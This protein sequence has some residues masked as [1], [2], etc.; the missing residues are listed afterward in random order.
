M[1]M[2]S[3]QQN[4]FTLVEVL[5]ALIV[6]AI[7][8][9]GLITLQLNTIQANKSASHRSQAVWAANDILDRMRANRTAALNS[10]YDIALATDAPTDT[11]TVANADL[12]DW[13]TR[14]P[15]TLPEGDG[16]VVT[17][18]ATS[19]VTVTIQWNE[20]RMRDGNNAMQFVLE[21]QI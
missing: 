16:S 10:D 6:M 14:L 17:D 13:L 1:K 20:G 15:N 5:V 7:G 3:G 21:T 8:V 9:M 12:A 18:A 19:T 4:G 11:S 2:T